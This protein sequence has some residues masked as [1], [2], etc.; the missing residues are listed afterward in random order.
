[1]DGIGSLGAF[2]RAVRLESARQQRARDQRLPGPWC[3]AVRLNR[4]RRERGVKRGRFCGKRA[5]M[6]ESG[7][8]S[9]ELAEVIS[10]QER[11]KGEQDQ[12]RLSLF[13]S[14]AYLLHIRGML[15]LN[16]NDKEVEALGG[17]PPEQP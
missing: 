11:G 3:C 17:T 13:T 14:N 8:C 1:M 2:S 12:R 15:F 16:A 9:P 5:G 7:G 6:G 10:R 4:R